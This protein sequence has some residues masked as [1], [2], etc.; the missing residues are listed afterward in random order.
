MIGWKPGS[1]LIFPSYR[2]QASAFSEIDTFL[3]SAENT[4]SRRNRPSFSLRQS[5]RGQKQEFFRFQRF[6]TRLFSLFIEKSLVSV[7]RAY[8]KKL[9]AANACYSF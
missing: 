4:P 8:F 2:L 3:D 9:P 1:G 7:F 6:S 5:G